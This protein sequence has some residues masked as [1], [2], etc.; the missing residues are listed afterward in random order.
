M[1]GLKLYRGLW[2]GANADRQHGRGA[3]RSERTRPHVTARYYGDTFVCTFPDGKLVSG[4]SN[5]GDT[6]GLC[7]NAAGDVFITRQY[8]IYEHA[9]GQATQI[10]T[11]AARVRGRAP[12]NHRATCMR[13][14]ICHPARQIVVSRD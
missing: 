10:A 5:T 1:T 2:R 8:A 9:D 4:M 6:G 14:A 13:R 12:Q 11:L 7:T 3:S